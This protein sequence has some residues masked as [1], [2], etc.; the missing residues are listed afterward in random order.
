MPICSNDIKS[1]FETDEV[2]QGKGR[3]WIP[4]QGD[5]YSSQEDDQ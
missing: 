3:N 2:I 4:T 1:C 5:A